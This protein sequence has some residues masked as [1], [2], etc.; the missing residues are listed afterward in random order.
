M[1]RFY[2][3]AD[4]MISRH[5]PVLLTGD[6]G[7]GKSTLMEVGAFTVKLNKVMLLDATVL[8]NL[9]QIPL[10]SHVYYVYIYVCLSS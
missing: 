2:Y 8:T 4:L 9:L 10:V 7:V 1:E 6:V 3:L 5:Y